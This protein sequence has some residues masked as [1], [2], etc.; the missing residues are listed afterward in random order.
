MTGASR[1]YVNPAV[2]LTVGHPDNLLS[3]NN[4]TNINLLPSSLRD[5]YLNI[6]LRQKQLFDT[7]QL[8]SS[9]PQHDPEYIWS[10]FQANWVYYLF[11]HKK[12]THKETETYFLNIITLINSPTY[13]QYSRPFTICE[14][15]V[16]LLKY[17][18][19]LK[20]TQ[21]N[22]SIISFLSFAKGYLHTNI[23]K[24]PDRDF[25][26]MNYTNNHALHNTRALFFLSA[27]FNDTSLL[28][29]SIALF[30]HLAPILFDRGV[31]NEGSTHYHLISQVVINDIS[32]FYP[33]AAL[34]I[35]SDFTCILLYFYQISHRQQFTP[36]IGDISPDPCIPYCLSH[37]EHHFSIA[38]IFS[39]LNNQ[40][41]ISHHQDFVF[42]KARDFT[43]LLHYRAGRVHQQHSHNDCF[44][45]LIWFKDTPLTLDV[46]RLNYTRDSIQHTLTRSHSVPSINGLD[47]SPRRYRDIY[48]SSALVNSFQSFSAEQ[49][50][51]CLDKL[52]ISRH[53]LPLY[54]GAIN[55]FATRVS[56]GTWHR[57]ICYNEMTASL[58]IVDTLNFLHPAD[59]CFRYFLSKTASQYVE[60]LFE[61]SLNDFAFSINEVPQNYIYSHPH[62]ENT[63]SHEYSFANVTNIYTIYTFTPHS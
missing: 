45:P 32:L 16:N 1:R 9:A 4:L 5:D 51:S 23:E 55:T 26:D 27:F 20:D 22:A 56:N 43:C 7:L 8:S 21:V 57:F 30:E 40:R 31:L 14:L 35:D 47:H 37:L 61:S 17:I 19:F 53:L 60:L 38:N 24:Y 44:A 18:T 15:C 46:G 28:L 12:L 36:V 10:L 39:L 25:R 59:I 54:G 2:N 34:C 33:Q 48:P 42:L 58:S 41:L 50:S 49:I 63:L 6:A 62:H 29:Y 11:E 52:N 13:L 3:S